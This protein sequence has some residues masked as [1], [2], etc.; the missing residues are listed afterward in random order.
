M[1]DS[2][3]VAFI[4]NREPFGDEVDRGVLY[5]VD[6]ADGAFRFGGTGAAVKAGQF[7]CLFHMRQLLFFLL[8]SV[9][10]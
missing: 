5:A 4:F 2:F 7:L 9:I 10:R 1:K 6:L 3:D 8:N